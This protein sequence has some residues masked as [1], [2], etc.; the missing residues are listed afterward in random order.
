MA[1]KCTCGPVSST[2]CGLSG[3]LV[4]VAGVA[5]LLVGLGMAEDVTT[6]I[7]VAGAALTLYG[8]G[9]LAHMLCLCPLCK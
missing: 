4:I 1:K 8:L 6:S 5:L 7:L 9:K 3:L 2:C